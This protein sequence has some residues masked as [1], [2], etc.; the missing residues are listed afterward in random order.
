LWQDGTRLKPT[1]KAI[2]RAF[3]LHYFTHLIEVENKATLHLKGSYK[4]EQEALKGRSPPVIRGTL[5]SEGNK[6]QIIFV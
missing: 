4:K 1:R 5:S 3:H 2:N 6:D